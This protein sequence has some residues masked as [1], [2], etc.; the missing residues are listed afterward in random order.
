[1]LGFDKFSEVKEYLVEGSIINPEY[2]AE[3]L[4]EIPDRWQDFD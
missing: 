2:I 1:M 3:K 4:S